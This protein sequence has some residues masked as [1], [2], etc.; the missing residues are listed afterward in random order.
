MDCC[1]L[2]L[3]VE[4]REKWRAVLSTAMNSRVT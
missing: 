4:D 2:D 3:F 1:G